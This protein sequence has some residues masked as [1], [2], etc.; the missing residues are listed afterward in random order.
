MSIRATFDQELQDV[1]DNVL[2]LG[3]M[4]DTAI[5]QSIQALK[6]RRYQSILQTH[7]QLYHGT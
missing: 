1:R 5:S 4:V 7:C 2:R 3:S 6:E